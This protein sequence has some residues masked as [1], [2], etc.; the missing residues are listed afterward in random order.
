MDI[1]EKTIRRKQQQ[2]FDK[3]SWT[4]CLCASIFQI[5]EN[6]VMGEDKKTYKHQ[7]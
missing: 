3:T 6:K 5:P 2:H 4:Y 7:F 1:D